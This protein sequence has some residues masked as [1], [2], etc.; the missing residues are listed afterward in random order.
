MKSG[1]RDT[2]YATEIDT[3]ILPLGDRQEAR[4]E[5]L[6]VKSTGEEEIRFSWWSTNSQGVLGF[7]NRPLDLNEDD[8]LRLFQ[9][10][11]AKKVFS[12]KFRAQLKTLL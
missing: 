9:I 6:L 4:L 11:L 12:E 1:M 5:R 8:L 7:A 10:A 3:A 2:E